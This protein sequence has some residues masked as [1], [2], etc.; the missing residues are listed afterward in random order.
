[1][2]RMLSSKRYQIECGRCLNG[3][4]RPLDNLRIFMSGTDANQLIMRYVTWC[5]ISLVTYANGFSAEW[6]IG[7][8]SEPASGIQHQAGLIEG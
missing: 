1:M 7:R 5:S 2:Q 3:L 8:H 4:N 6:P